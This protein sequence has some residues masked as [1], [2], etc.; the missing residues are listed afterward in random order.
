MLGTI[1]V[2]RITFYPSEEAARKIADANGG[3]TEGYRVAPATGR[4]GK[5]VIEVLDTEDNFK[6]GYL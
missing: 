4:A 1:I 6:L 3:E 5:Y 2:N